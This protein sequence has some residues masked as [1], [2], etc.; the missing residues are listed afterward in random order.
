MNILILKKKK[1]IIKGHWAP[2]VKASSIPITKV[3]LE[4]TNFA[5]IENLFAEST[6]DKG[7]S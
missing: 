4:S 7:I 6:I 1:K 5:E 3:H 2:Q